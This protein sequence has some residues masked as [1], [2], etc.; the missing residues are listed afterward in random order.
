MGVERRI[1]G[2]EEGMEMGTRKDLCWGLG[3]VEWNTEGGRGIGEGCD[4]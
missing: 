4:G 2:G 3:F 1:G